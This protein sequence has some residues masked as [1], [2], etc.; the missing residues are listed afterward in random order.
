MSTKKSA[1]K[2][3]APADTENFNARKAAA[4]IFRKLRQPK[5]RGAEYSLT[6]KKLRMLFKLLL[7]GNYREVACRGAGIAPATFYLYVKRAEDGRQAFEEQ[8]KY[9]EGNSEVFAEMLGAI[10]YCEANSEAEI[11]V[12]ASKESPIRFLQ[13]RYRDRYHPKQPMGIDLENP[14]FA[15]SVH[16]YL[17]TNG[18]EPDKSDTAP[19]D[20]PKGEKQ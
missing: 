3:Q 10:E 5:G 18:R 15:G 7:Q 4:A 8:G 1:K 19:T 2:K 14:N 16:I 6:E 13:L 12:K 11:V 9:P 20:K 17:P